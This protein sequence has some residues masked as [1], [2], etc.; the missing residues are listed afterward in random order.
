MS[1]YDRAVQGWPNGLPDW[2]RVLAEQCDL[3][4]QSKA[5]R[6]LGYSPA[7]VSLVLAG[8]YSGD[9]AKVEMAVRG[10]YLAALVACPVL[11]DIPTNDCLSHQRAPFA[12]TN[13]VRV[14][15]YRSCHGTCPH[16]SVKGGRHAE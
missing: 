8:T 14:Q 11:G 3:S 5:A 15:L 1:A 7:T 10:A 16:T 2:V 13:H 4:S 6:Q 9:L 12:P